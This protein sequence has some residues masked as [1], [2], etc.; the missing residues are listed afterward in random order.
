MNDINEW[1]AKYEALAAGI[2]DKT[3]IEN[4]EKLVEAAIKI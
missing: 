2:E 1:E 3:F 4:A